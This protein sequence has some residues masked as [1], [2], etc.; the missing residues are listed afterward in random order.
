MTRLMLGIALALCGLA[1]AVWLLRCQAE[2][3][4]R[5]GG[6][7]FAGCTPDSSGR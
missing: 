7:L 4:F 5:I 1:A 6:L 2:P 3:P